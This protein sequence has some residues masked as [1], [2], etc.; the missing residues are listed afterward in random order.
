MRFSVSTAVVQPYAMI[1]SSLASCKKTKCNNIACVH[2]VFFSC[3]LSNERDKKL[4]IYNFGWAELLCHRTKSHK[5]ECVKV[6]LVVD[7][8]RLQ[9]VHQLVRKLFSADELV[10]LLTFHASDAQ[11]NRKLMD[12]KWLVD[13]VVCNVN[14]RLGTELG[15]AFVVDLTQNYMIIHCFYRRKDKK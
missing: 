3:S 1:R 4:S 7:A 15:K 2:Q 5:Q 8:Q 6:W 12:L 10:N 14:M 13:R 9:N 11:L